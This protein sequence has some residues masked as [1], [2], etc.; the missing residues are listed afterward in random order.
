M[1]SKIIVLT[2]LLGML[3]SP[4]F[5]Q[6]QNLSFSYKG[7]PLKTIINDIEKQYNYSFVYSNTLDVNKPVTVTVSDK[8]LNEALDALCKAGSLAYKVNGRQ[9]VLS[10]V[11]TPLSSVTPL[12]VRTGVRRLVELL[13]GCPQ[14]RPYPSQ[15][16]DSRLQPA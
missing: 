8:G 7:T 3:F 15:E 9:I 16:P 5:M 14:Y 6:A 4:A 12:C 10:P 13:Q 1:K 2:L 11:S